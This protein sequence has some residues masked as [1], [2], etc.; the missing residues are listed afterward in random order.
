MLSPSE[1]NWGGGGAVV[2]VGTRGKTA[3]PV[4]I[5]CTEG[6]PAVS[7]QNFLYYTHTH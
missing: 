1:K 6:R 2:V 3:Q 7:Q 4:M 5:N